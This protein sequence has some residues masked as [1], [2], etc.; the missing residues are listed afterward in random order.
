LR[1]KALRYA[2]ETLDLP[3]WRP[4]ARS[5][6]PRLRS[7]QDALGALNDADSAEGLLKRLDLSGDPRREAARLV[8]G[9]K[10]REDR[11]RAR[12]AVRRLVKSPPAL[13]T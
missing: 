9:L 3:E 5:L 4:L 11:A 2:L 7:A 13:F 12:K 8:A 10:R 6:S 1:I